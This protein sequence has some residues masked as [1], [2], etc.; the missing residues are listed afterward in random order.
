MSDVILLAHGSGGGL[1]HEL[2]ARVFA[3][4]FA[5]PVLARLDVL[6]LVVTLVGDGFDPL[7]AEHLFGGTGGW[8]PRSLLIS[9]RSLPA[10]CSGDQPSPSLPTT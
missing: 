3:P 9:F 6:A 2:V 7:D 1:S 10:I 5:N 4:A 8:R